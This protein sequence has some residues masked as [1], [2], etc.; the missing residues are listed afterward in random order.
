MIEKE[1]MPVSHQM[2]VDLCQF[3]YKSM[4]KM[5]PTQHKFWEQQLEALSKQDNPRSMRWHPMMI[6]LALHLQSAAPAAIAILNESGV[7]KL[8]SERL[9]FDFTH[10]TE[11]KV[12]IQEV[13]IGRVKEKLDKLNPKEDEKYFNLLF[14]EMYVKEDIV[15]NRNGEIVGCVN[16]SD[17]E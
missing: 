6:K 4:D 17:I 12:G 16:L 10:F 2:S 11:A 9:L 1:S 3:F 14:D 5:S 15:V 8:P 13:V 7:I